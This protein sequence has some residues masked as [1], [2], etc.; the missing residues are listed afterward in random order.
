MILYN[1]F[2]INYSNDPILNLNIE[3]YKHLISDE[4]V[5]IVG[6]GNFTNKFPYFLHQDSK[7]IQWKKEGKK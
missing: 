1:V 2:N 7:V 5:L 6:L 4:Y 3:K